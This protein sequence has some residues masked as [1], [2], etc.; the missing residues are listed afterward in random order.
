[1]RFIISFLLLPFFALTACAQGT[2]GVNIP[3][4]QTFV[5]GEYRTDGYRATLRNEGSQ[6]VT[7]MIVD[8][9]S[10]K[11]VS[12]V[13]LPVGDRK[14]LTIADG[15]EVH[16][17][18]EGDQKA[19]VK[20]KSPVKG[21]QGM[22]YID[23]AS[24]GKSNRVFIPRPAPATAPTSAT[25]TEADDATG[26]TSASVT[27]LPGQALIIGENSSMNYSVTIRN[28]GAQIDVAG[29]DKKTGKQMQGFGL[30]KMGRETV[31]VRPNEDLYLIN[32]SEKPTKVKV[33]MD[34]PVRGVRVGK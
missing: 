1:M 6:A 14:S 24:N 32:T 33:K 29:R 22:R 8:Q 20:V 2:S 19:L 28:A 34:K 7:A 3:A 5:L 4:G 12:T 30:G 31:N 23:P 11:A 26:E 21:S 15:Q 25:T 18:N 13:D 10:G 17:K 16:L 9:Q 27:L